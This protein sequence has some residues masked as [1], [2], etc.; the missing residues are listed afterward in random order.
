[1]CTY[2]IVVYKIVLI[3]WKS[4]SE[5][6]Q[7]CPTLCDPM[8]HSP[9]GSPSMEFSR[10]EYW[11]GLPF[12]S[13]GNLPDTGIEPGSPERQADS[14]VW[15]TRIFYLMKHLTFFLFCG[16]CRVHYCLAHQMSVSSPPPHPLPQDNQK[17][18]QL[19][20]NV[21]LGITKSLPVKNHC[22]K[23]YLAWLFLWNISQKI[24]DY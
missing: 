7:L 20:S 1:M 18:L 10:Q 2:C 11:S 23:V 15:A 16:V 19:L 24:R 8:D 12:P 4:E 22:P 6:A 13:P 9:P 3:K 21:P 5:V 17:C 14:T